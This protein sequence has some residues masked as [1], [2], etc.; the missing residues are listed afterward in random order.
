M[1]PVWLVV[2][3]GI[4]AALG[5]ATE[6]MGTWVAIGAGLGVT[7]SIVLAKRPPTPPRSS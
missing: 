4:G 6:N 5:A 3:V 1:N 7:F 2:G